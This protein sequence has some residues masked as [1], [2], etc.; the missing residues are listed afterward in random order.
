[1]SGERR[2]PVLGVLGG[3]GPL[4]AAEFLRALALE[5][6]ATRDQDHLRVVLWGDP[7]V[8]DRVAPILRGEGPSPVPALLAGVRALEVAGATFLA[9]PCN[10]AHSW[11][12]ELQ[13]AT[14]L[15][16]LH[17]AHAAAD[18]LAA[19]LTTGEPADAAGQGSGHP[20]R[21]AL[22]ATKATLAARIFDAPLRARGCEPEAPP[23]ADQDGVLLPA[24]AAIKRGAL[25]DARVAVEGLV[26]R[27]F[28]RGAD[29]V[30]LACT[31]LTAVASEAPRP[32]L[33]VDAT[34]ALA[35]VALRHAGYP[36]G[37]VPQSR[38]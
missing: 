38:P 21:V 22:F 12:A 26:A 11:H 20:A 3:M 37:T 8:P 6:P 5:T 27:A 10:T 36:V 28:E 25:D 29:A 16:F 1:M 35:R 31:E 30:L 23:D 9:M 17:I 14:A 7:T 19:R 32:R 13:A 2:A 18:D 34:R 15:P 33:V 24:I 4:A